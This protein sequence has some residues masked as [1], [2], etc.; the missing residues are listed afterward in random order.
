MSEINVNNDNSSTRKSKQEIPTYVFTYEF[1]PL[2]RMYVYLCIF[3]ILCLFNEH[4]RVWKRSKLDL[5][6]W[7]CAN[8][9]I[10]FRMATFQHP[11]V[12][13]YLLKNLRWLLVDEKRRRI[14][15]GPRGG[16]ESPPVR[17]VAV[18]P[19]LNDT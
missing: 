4:E 6:P 19:H 15:Q 1:T 9:R 12:W 8:T 18:L 17:I 16:D 5:L 14:C 13:I 2:C 3:F 11:L 10:S 7:F